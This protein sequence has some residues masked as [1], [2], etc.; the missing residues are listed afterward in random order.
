MLSTLPAKDAGHPGPGNYWAFPRE[1]P[2]FA[3][4]LSLHSLQ[5]SGGLKSSSSP[6]SNPRICGG[7]HS[8]A[9]GG[10]ALWLCLLEPPVAPRGSQQC[11]QEHPSPDSLL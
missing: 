4:H 3:I 9:P 2:S 10:T 8:R 11:G 7:D 5:P 1:E 6:I